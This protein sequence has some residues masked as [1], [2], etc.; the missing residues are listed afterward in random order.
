MEPVASVRQ[1]LRRLDGRPAI[2]KVPEALKNFLEEAVPRT[3]ECENFVKQLHPDPVSLGF[4]LCMVDTVK[5]TS[6]LKMHNQLFP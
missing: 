2:K 1:A 4:N 5:N 3:H 6:T